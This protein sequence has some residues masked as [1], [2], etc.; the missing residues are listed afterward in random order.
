[1]HIK[2]A[3]FSHMN[4]TQNYATSVLKKNI[5][6]CELEKEDILDRASIQKADQFYN[7]QN[8]CLNLF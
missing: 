3:L 4:H 5:K 7:K 2:Y 8:I 1:M 6:T